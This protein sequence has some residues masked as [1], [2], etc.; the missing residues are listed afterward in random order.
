MDAFRRALEDAN[1]ADLVHLLGVTIDTLLKGIFGETG[2]GYG[3]CG[4]E[5]L[6][7]FVQDYQRLASAL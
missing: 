4:V 6:I 3:Q 2:Y 7:P 5:V 1:L